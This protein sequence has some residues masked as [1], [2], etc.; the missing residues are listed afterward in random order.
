MPDTLLLVIFAGLALE[1]VLFGISFFLSY[2]KKKIPK[3]LNRAIYIIGIII[4]VLNIFK[5]AQAGATMIFANV[6][7]IAALGVSWFRIETGKAGHSEKDDGAEE[8]E[9]MERGDISEGKKNKG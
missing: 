9:G 4:V 7:V 2:K 6:L 1:L 8:I 3:S 5:Q